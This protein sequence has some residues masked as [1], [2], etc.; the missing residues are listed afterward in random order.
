MKIT[1]MT[2]FLNGFFSFA[3]QAQGGGSNASIGS[4]DTCVICMDRKNEPTAISPCNHSFCK[5]CIQCHAVIN[6]TDREGDTEYVAI[7]W[8]NGLSARLYIGNKRQ[9]WVG[10]CW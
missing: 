5:E 1:L 2:I 3:V 6:I 9:A 4:I 10:C 8:N 7:T